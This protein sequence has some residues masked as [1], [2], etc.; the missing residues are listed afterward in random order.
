MK[1]TIKDREVEILRH[2]QLYYTGNAEISDQEFDRLEEELRNLYPAS[3]VL[4]KV[5]YSPADKIPHKRP[6]LSLE[7]VKDIDQLK[8]WIGST[9]CVVSE[10]LDGSSCSIIYRWGEFYQAKTR[11][12]GQFGENITE[13]INFINFPH[14]V[15][16]FSD[17]EEV[18]VRGEVIITRDDFLKLIKAVLELG[19]EPPS[20]MRNCVA[21]LLHRKTDKHLCKY[22]TFCAYDSDYSYSAREHIQLLKL[23]DSGF[24]TPFWILFP[25]GNTLEEVMKISD[26]DY[27][28]TDGLVISIDDREDQLSRG[29]TDHHPKGKIAFKFASEEAETTIKGILTDVGRTG[30]V[31]FVGEVEPVELSGAVISRVTLHNASYIEDHSINIGSQILITRSNEVI[32]KHVK[33]LASSGNYT[34]PTICPSCFSSLVRE[35]VDL[36]CKN[37]K[38][39]AQAIG[40]IANWIKML[41]IDSIGDETLG[42]M[43]NTG[44]IEAI[45]D[46]YKVTVADLMKM[47]KLGKRSATK[48]VEN[49]QNTKEIPLEIFLSACGIP[50]VG[51]GTAKLLTINYLSLDKIFE[52]VLSGRSFSSIEGI[53]S[54]TSASLIKYFSGSGQEL[55]Q[56]LRQ[57]GVSIKD[58][59]DLSNRPLS[60]L[61][62]VITGTLSKPRKAVENWIETYG[63]K[64]SGSVSAQT[65]YLVCNELSGSTKSRKATELGVKVITE[66][67]LYKIVNGG[68]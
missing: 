17:F 49:I 34:F 12:D 64:L 63:G 56:R 8:K 45:P 18:E 33:T 24:K 19:Q 35:G 65:N 40:K 59:E 52:V 13:H 48:I 11:G 10:K 41:S 67:D 14:K 53:G 26:H 44:L 39:P 36:Y 37:E 23:G 42:K 58:A 62:F 31:T 16:E 46:L 27:Y 61:R 66:E 51:M 22:L 5:G 60:G 15:A 25:E 20:S 30:K 43:F 9:P 32:P 57:A 54:V 55:V 4:S 6:M 1:R 29:F 68:F 38:C 7:K 28:L 3:P 47:D 2:K 50:N 21:G